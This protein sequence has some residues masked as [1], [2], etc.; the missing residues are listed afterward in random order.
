MRKKTYTIGLDYGS[1]SCRGVLADTQD[2]RIL[3]EAEFEYP[4]GIMESSLPD[5][6]ILSGEWF[7]QHPADYVEALEYIVP[8]LLRRSEVDPQAI[9]GIGIDFT[10]GT[11]VPMDEQ[12]VPLSENP[13]YAS[14][15]H[16]WT[17]LWKCKNADAQAERLAKI[18]R[19]QNR[20]YLGLCGGGVNPR[21]LLPKVIQVFEEDREIYDAADCF[22]EA[23]DYVTSLLAGHPVCGSSAAASKTFWSKETGYPDEEFFRAVDEALAKLPQ[24]K[25][26]DHFPD[27]QY[28]F[29]GE[30]VGELCP[31]M[32]KRLGLYAGIAVSAPQMD[33]W[34]AVPG[35]GICAPGSM[36][37]IIGTS[38]V[39]IA[40][41]Q[42]LRTVTGASACLPDAHYPGLCS[43]VSGQA[44]VGDG[45]QWFIDHFVPG[46]YVQE[47]KEKGMNLHG[48][49]TELAS[50]MVPGQTGLLALDWLNGSQASLKTRYPSGLLL[51]MNLQ[52]KPEHI[53]RAL[54]ESTA[55][56][57]RKI[58]ENYVKEGIPVEE[59]VASGGIAGKNALMMQIYADVLGKPVKVKHCT[60]ASALGAAISAASA[61]GACTGYHCF[62]DAVEAMGSRQCS[63]YL[64][65]EKNQETYNM[66]YAE[67]CALYDYFGQGENRV[68]DR[69]KVLKFT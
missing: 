69:L 18:C 17:K 6:T 24:E 47:A 31:E 58:M 45:F 59:I 41:G 12:F 25:L 62:S 13:Q 61:A 2:G 30:K 11:M 26:M 52:T 38:S 57:A 43:F 19:E 7:L 32:A 49:L 8:A 35:V 50:G 27:C 15:H 66:L 55:F 67:Y 42:E 65:D 22:M 4:H 9:V 48:Y 51:G 68:M 3:A 34:A 23:A 46:S 53:Y 20:P 14:R 36:L 1:L 28:G 60:Y 40:L 64:P 54:L 29:P 63:V 37:L 33:A 44:S 39:A 10:V 16:A 5:G 56:G 21:W